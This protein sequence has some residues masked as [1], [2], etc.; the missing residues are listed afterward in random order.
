MTKNED[1]AGT[2]ESLRHQIKILQA[3]LEEATKQAS[4]ATALASVSSN[5][6]NDVSTL[7]AK[8]EDATERAM[9]AERQLETVS[10]HHAM[11]KR[12][13]STVRESVGSCSPI[14]PSIKEQTDEE[15]GEEASSSP[16]D[17]KMDFEN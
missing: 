2:N 15:E 16:V 14:M 8:L 13:Q 17:V 9:V 5:K 3:K 10:L 7:K 6:D 11:N 1:T 12:R 4:D